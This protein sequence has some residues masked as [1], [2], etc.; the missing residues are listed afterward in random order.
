TAGENDGQKMTSERPTVILINT[1]LS[2]AIQ[3][4]TTRLGVAEIIEKPVDT[5][6]LLA[7]VRAAL[8]DGPPSP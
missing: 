4:R 7:C 5:T 2:E 3:K 8:A 6:H 1:Y